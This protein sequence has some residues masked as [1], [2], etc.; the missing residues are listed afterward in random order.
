MSIITWIFS[1][2]VAGATFISKNSKKVTDHSE[3][4]DRDA[5]SVRKGLQPDHRLYSQI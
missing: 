4:S 1:A 3:E 2:L 5:S